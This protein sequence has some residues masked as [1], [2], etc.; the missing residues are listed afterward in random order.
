MMLEER[1]GM[2]SWNQETIKLWFEWRMRFLTFLK[3]KFAV[4]TSRNIVYSEVMFLFGLWFLVGVV[5]ISGRSKMAIV[6]YH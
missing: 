6:K 3:P 4:K 2:L 1:A 5:N